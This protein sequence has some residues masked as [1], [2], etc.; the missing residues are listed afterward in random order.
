MQEGKKRR[1]L[2]TVLVRCDGLARLA[3]QKSKSAHC[4]GPS[5]V[6]MPGRSIPRATR[7]RCLGIPIGNFLYSKSRDGFLIHFD[8]ARVFE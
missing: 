1:S 5:R 3:E 6:E 2:E 4:G 8:A 7:R